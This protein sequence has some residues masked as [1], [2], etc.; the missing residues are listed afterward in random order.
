[1]MLSLLFILQAVTGSAQTPTPIYQLSV[2]SSSCVYSAELNGFPLTSAH[3]DQDVSVPLNLYL[4]G[5]SNQ[6]KI[7]HKGEKCILK[8]T[9]FKQTQETRTRIYEAK[10]ART[11]R[12]SHTFDT[13]VNA[14][15]RWA[16]SVPYT[17]QQ[18]LKT[19][20]IRLVKL[21]SSAQ[22]QEYLSLS[23]PK[24]RDYADAFGYPLSV[25]EESLKTSLKIFEGA[26]LLSREEV[27][28][29]PLLGGRLWRLKGSPKH[30]HLVKIKRDD[31][32]LSLEVIV[33][34]LRGELR[35]V[36]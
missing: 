9:V 11:A 29:E 24:L 8:I 6:L 12:L 23:A 1:M 28:L 16:R 32:E 13:Q 2:E 14:F 7:S 5:S 10:G 34:S 19:F 26:P 4:I 22:H 21:L 18:S 20:A 27:T 33:G 36:R 3:E 25:F 30:Q 15:H 35:I 17:N 31:E